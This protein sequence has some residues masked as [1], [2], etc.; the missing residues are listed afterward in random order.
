MREE[1]YKSV[2]RKQSN[3]IEKNR[4]E[5]TDWVILGPSSCS[6][7]IQI[8]KEKREKNDK[9]AD[10]IKAFDLK[11]HI[12]PDSI[13]NENQEKQDARYDDVQKPSKFHRLISEL[14]QQFAPLS[15]FIPRSETTF[16]REDT[17]R[18]EYCK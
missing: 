3:Q 2:E 8:Q 10:Q 9:F 12:L 14:I 18:I 4:P 16:V 17:Q 13:S 5:R 1:G 7:E 6:L 15:E 11:L